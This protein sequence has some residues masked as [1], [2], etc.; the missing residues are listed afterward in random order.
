MGVDLCLKLHP[1]PNDQGHGASGSRNGYFYPMSKPIVIVGAGLSGTLLAVRLAQRGFPVELYESRPDMRKTEISAGRSINLALSDRGLRALEMIGV[2]EDVIRGLIPMEGRMIHHQTGN[3]HFQTYSGREGEHINSVSRGGLNM[4]LLDQ[5]EV[6][7]NLTLRFDTP[8]THVDLETGLAHFRD[9]TNGRSFI[10]EASLVIGADGAGSAVRASMLAQGPRLRFDYRQDWLSH[11]YKELSF[12]PTRDGQWAIEKHALHIW[13]RGGFM[14]IA[15]PNPDGSFTV[16]LFLPF[17]GET[18]FEAMP[19]GPSVRRYFEN[20]F[21]DTLPLMPELETEYFA[22]PTSSLGTIKCYPWS[23]YGKT[24]LIGDAAHA[25]V[26]F[27]GQGMNCS[28]EDCRI[29][30]ACL[31][32]FGDD[33]DRLLPDFQARRKPNADAI[34]DLAVENF[35]EMRDHVADPVFIRKRQLETRLEARFPDYFSKY[36]L[37]TFREDVP[38]ALARELGNAQD[39]I[40]ME[41]CAIDCSLDTLD[42]EGI[43]NE[44]K[45]RTADLR[46]GI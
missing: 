37:V 30:D 8:C 40:L 3:T 19:D 41:L 26:P 11:G 7:P 43:L 18:G 20:W 15:L 24:V 17:S 14:M 5:A 35:Y 39:R 36:S 29:F 44:V 27:Y 42:L 13:P 1:F 28:F 38:Y 25:V 16:T 9:D 23:A 22:N 2:H 32:E 46:Q 45:R 10:R 34:A 6:F 31:D 4:A 21:P 33:W 12:P